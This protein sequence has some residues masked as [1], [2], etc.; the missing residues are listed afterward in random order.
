MA[1]RVATSQSRSTKVCSTICRWPCNAHWKLIPIAG[2]LSRCRLSSILH[3][4]ER[5]ITHRAGRH[6]H[7]RKTLLAEMILATALDLGLMLPSLLHGVAQH[8]RHTLREAVNLPLL[9]LAIVHTNTVS[10]LRQVDQHLLDRLDQATILTRLRE[11][12]LLDP[13]A[14]FG[15]MLLVDLLLNLGLERCKLGRCENVAHVC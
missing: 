2:I 8:D 9:V 7:A 10:A 6:A 11:H 5:G 1:L 12:V 4:Q 15:L 14:L 13:L 3:L